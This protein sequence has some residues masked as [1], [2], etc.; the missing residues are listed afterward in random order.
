MT[1]YS[2]I[3]WKY[4]GCGWC[5]LIW[6]LPQDCVIA[7]TMTKDDESYTGGEGVSNEVR[8]ANA[9]FAVRC[10]NAHDALVEALAGICDY[11]EDNSDVRA[12]YCTD[13]DLFEVYNR[14]AAALADAKET[15]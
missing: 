2:P 12:I 15:P 1:E 10:V 14:A 5:G 9:R 13:P 6:S 4:C 11:I 7:A 3:P 8:V